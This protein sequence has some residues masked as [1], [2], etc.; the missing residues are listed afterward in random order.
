MSEMN[1]EH[2]YDTSATDVAEKLKKAR[3]RVTAFTLSI[4][5]VVGAIVLFMN[6]KKTN[7]VDYIEGN[8]LKIGRSDS[9]YTGN[10]WRATNFISQ[11]TWSALFSTD[12][13]FT[14]VNPDLAESINISS[15]GLVYT[16]V[17]KDGLLWSDGTPLT[18]DDVVFSIESALLCSDSAATVHTVPMQQILGVEAW[19]EV[20]VESWE[21]GGTHSLEGLS[22]DGNTLTITL[23]NPYQ[24]FAFALTQ[25]VILPKHALDHI[26]PST[27]N[28][29]N[30]DYAEFAKDPVCSGMFM[31]DKMVNDQD[32]ELIQNPNYHGEQTEL[33][34][35]IAYE[36]YQTMYID[37]FSTSSTTEMVSYRNMEGF[38]EYFVDVLFYRYF[39]F[40]LMGGYDNP[41]MV[42]QLDEDGKK[43][44]DDDGEVVMVAEYGDDREENLPMQ[45]Y[46]LRQAISLAI[47][48]EA[49]ARDVYLGN[50]RYQF[51]RTGNDA[52]IDFLS[53]QDLDRAKELLAESGYDMNRPIKIWHYH[54]D[55]NSLAMRARVQEGL[56]AI[57]LTVEVSKSQNGL[58]GMY[59]TREYDIL[60]KGYAAQNSTEWYL[61]YVSSVAYVSELLG[62]TEFDQLLLD[63]EGAVSMEDYAK[64]WAE[65][66][67][68][69]RNT[70]YRIPIVTSNDCTYINGNRI[71]VPEDMM[72]GNN[73]YRYDLRLDE[74][75][76]KKA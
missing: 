17:L 44:L 65:M 24:S 13:T 73:R 54:T 25:F 69:D 14:E 59:E 57:G 8:V 32:L 19:Q 29:F 46:L 50:A 64:V 43:V 9:V 68:L 15:D 18:L 75:Y 7:D 30:E 40:N 42:P 37:Y 36:G 60:L 16:I 2:N 33:E 51:E 67:E 31:V 27:I 45:N 28:D 70:M 34:R 12:A 47:D 35:V 4:V 23:A 72:F 55:A 56:E 3:L 48:R 58:V 63:L 6:W 76:V 71:S 20:G 21:N 1:T 61:E 66:Q 26:D 52:Y 49:I 5:V 38:E 53:T 41:T 74:W 22:V 39:I 11:L 10:V 62:V